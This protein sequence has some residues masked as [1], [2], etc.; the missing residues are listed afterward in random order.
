M[1]KY[2][3]TIM[4]VGLLL[5]IVLTV[6]SIYGA[7]IGAG[8]AQQ[9]FN[10]P[11]LAVYWTVL[12]ILLIAGI[13]AFLLP[14]C[15]DDAVAL[16]CCITTG[17]FSRAAESSRGRGT[18]CAH[19]DTGAYRLVCGPA[20]GPL[21]LQGSGSRSHRDDY[22]VGGIDR[23]SSDG[24]SADAGIRLHGVEESEMGAGGDVMCRGTD[25]A[26]RWSGS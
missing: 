3:R 17:L 23:D 22:L 26:H 5:I 12:A 1:Y 14:V 24:V 10:Q 4:W 6:L 18:F 2:R 15:P 20:H 16:L 13:A 7:F 19:C 11:Q 21:A 25:C 9:F 8:R